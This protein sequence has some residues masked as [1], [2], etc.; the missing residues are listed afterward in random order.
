MDTWVM[1]VLG[2]AI[3]ALPVVLMVGFNGPDRTDSHGRRTDR[4]WRDS[5][6]T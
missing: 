5:T 2:L 6:R 3:A 4:R 1:W